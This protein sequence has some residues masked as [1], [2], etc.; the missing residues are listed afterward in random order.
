MRKK[1]IAE[2]RAAAARTLAS[3][4]VSLVSPSLSRETAASRGHHN[5]RV[6]YG[7]LRVLPLSQMDDVEAQEL[8]RSLQQKAHDWVKEQRPSFLKKTKIGAAADNNNNV[9]AGGTMKKSTGKPDAATLFSL[10]VQPWAGVPV[11]AQRKNSQTPPPKRAVSQQQQS[12]PAFS[13]SPAVHAQGAGRHAV[14]RAL[15]SSNREL[16]S[17]ID[18]VV[19]SSP[20][21]VTGALRNP[22]PSRPLG[23][24]AVAREQLRKVHALSTALLL[25][26][27]RKQSSSHKQ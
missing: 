19:A 27:A 20:W 6:R 22:T 5:E 3:P 11:P 18:A 14:A 24:G 17:N 4:A 9:A 21:C 7:Q 25:A 1:Q 13:S 12:S 15:G 2:Q 23:T 26:A 8:E 16:K 10:S